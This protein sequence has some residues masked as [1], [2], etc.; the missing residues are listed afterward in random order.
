[1]TV[2]EFLVS[3]K[4]GLT[5]YGVLL[6][7]ALL[8]FG[9]GR[10]FWKYEKELCNENI[11]RIKDLMGGFRNR[12]IEPILTKI[13]DMAFN[14]GYRQAIDEL[15]RDLYIKKRNESGEFE[16]ELVADETLKAL[17]GKAALD[18]RLLNVKS[19]GIVEQFLSSTSGDQLFDNLDHA[20]ERQSV[21]SRQYHSAC[22][23]CGRASYSFFSLSILLLAGI[24]RVFGKWPDVIF[25]L[26]L[27]LS[28]LTF[29][30]GIYHFVR[31]EI[32]RR[33]LL[34]MWEELQIYG[35]I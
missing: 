12:Y 8:S 1:M 31:L 11:D 7:F 25:F 23:A 27:F 21:L 29:L 4:P 16:H 26:W 18:G 17:L 3:V 28:L 24:L 14:D 19:I 32:H 2:E 15:I 22:Q 9:V 34:R 10:F 6:T 13:L 33:S 5:L 35:K 20:Y 30:Y